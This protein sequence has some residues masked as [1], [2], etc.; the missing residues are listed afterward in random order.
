[1]PF[2]LSRFSVKTQ[3]AAIGTCA[4]AG[5]LMV[6]GIYANGQ[7]SAARFKAS[8]IAANELRELATGM[9]VGLLEM[10]RAE[11][12]FFLRREERYV[13]RHEKFAKSLEAD[14]PKVA[15][16]LGQFLNF[17]AYSRRLQLSARALKLTVSTSTKRSIL[18]ASSVSPKR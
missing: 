1:M 12:D 11:K 4:V 10:R 5:I 18:N 2:K 17:P 13:E 15:E 16:P 14:I 3:I 8:Q 6:G 9:N 7:S